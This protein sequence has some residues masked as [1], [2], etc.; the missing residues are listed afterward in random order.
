MSSGSK[1]VEK[2]EIVTSL[3]RISG[4][5]FEV[6]FDDPRYPKLI[7]DEP[8]PLGSGE[9]PNPVRLLSAAVGEC[10]SSGLVYCL[11][12]AKVRIKR[13]ETG[14]GMEL[15]KEEE[16][17]W[18]IKGVMVEVDLLVAKRDT[19]RARRS[20]ERFEEYCT[21]TLGLR[22]GTPVTIDVKLG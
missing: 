1:K 21:V 16:G 15:V 7:V 8:E 3:K 2:L 12:K 17:Y 13:L 6:E 4:H 18:R 9:G 19:T 14:V 22:A 11:D 20:L 5:K 10:V